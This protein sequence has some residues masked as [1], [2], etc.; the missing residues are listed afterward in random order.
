[1]DSVTIDRNGYA[2]SIMQS[3]TS[4]CFRCGRTT[5]KLDRHEPFG[6]ALRSKSKRYGMWCMLCHETCHLGIVHRIPAENAKLREIAQK[7]A[8]KEYGWTTEDFIREFGR[9]YL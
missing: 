5:G 2:P 6:S 4:Y 8:M 3:D 1:M 7:A 9:N